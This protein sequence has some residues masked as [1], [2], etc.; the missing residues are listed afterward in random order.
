LKKI[1]KSHLV[2]EGYGCLNVSIKGMSRATINLSMGVYAFLNRSK[3]Q[4]RMG[5]T[6]VG[7]GRA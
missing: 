7:P 4:N 3:C 5:P 1:Q 2:L 6:Y